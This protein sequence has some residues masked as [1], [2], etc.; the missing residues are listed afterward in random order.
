MKAVNEKAGALSP[1]KTGK[2][3]ASFVFVQGYQKST[4]IPAGW[5]RRKQ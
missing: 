2:Q 1:E 3:P 5:E 4:A